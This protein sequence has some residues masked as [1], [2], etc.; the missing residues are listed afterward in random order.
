MPCERGLPAGA[1]D[2]LIGGSPAP[3]RAA[4]P[5]PPEAIDI[6]QLCYSGRAALERARAVRDTL[7]A[8]LDAGPGL[9][10]VEPLLRFIPPACLTCPAGLV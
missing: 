1:L 7:A 9:S 8:S 6:R 4:E 10:A 3:A 5:P 2:E